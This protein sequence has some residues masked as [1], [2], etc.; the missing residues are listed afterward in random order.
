MAKHIIIRKGM[1]ND[2]IFNRSILLLINA[3][4]S[5]NGKYRS[6]KP[7]DGLGWK[8]NIAAKIQGPT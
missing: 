3:T 8:G 7:V 4:Y 5:I 6:T 1:D 2:G